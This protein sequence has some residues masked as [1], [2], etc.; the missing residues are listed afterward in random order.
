MSSLTKEQI[1]A[2]RPRLEEIEVPEW[3][4]S[5]FIRSVTLAEQARL[6]DL[7]TKFEKAPVVD[8]MK[9]I[10]LR[11]LQWAVS[12]AEGRPLFEARDLEELMN[13]PAGGSLRLQESILKLSGLT[14][15]A[16]RDLE[17]NSPSARNEEPGFD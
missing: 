6:A 15:E 2:V 7:G 5:V 11:L 12:D 3:G 14:E 16:R 4:G 13:K 17:K 8:R 1:F 9:N 10:T